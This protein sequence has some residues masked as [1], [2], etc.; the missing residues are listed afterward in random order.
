VTV[1]GYQGTGTFQTEVMEMTGIRVDRAPSKTS[2]NVGERADLAGIKVMGSW[3]D[4]PDAEVPAY[5]V[6]VASFDSSSAG[7]RVVT[8]DY[9]GKRA[10][11]PVTVTVPAT[12]APAASQPSQPAQQQPSTPAPSASTFNPAANQPS[13]V[14]SWRP[15]T[16][17]IVTF[18]ANGTGTMKAVSST[19]EGSPFTWSASGNR[20]TITYPQ[21]GST[22][23]Y[24]YSI[25]GNTFTWKADEWNSP[26]TMTRQ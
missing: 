17:P 26:A 4:F 16:G 20:L 11:F 9:K 14:G 25:S 19:G 8:V 3:R 21:Y 15:A 23:N 7:N 1:L 22:E 24:L 2:Y 5:Q 13:P 6:T 12:P 10:T 18:N